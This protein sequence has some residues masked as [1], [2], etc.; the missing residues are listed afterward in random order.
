[1][2]V[3]RRMTRNV[4]TASA[5]DPVARAASLMRENRIHH[6]PVVSGSELEGIVTDTDIRNAALGDPASA[7]GRTVGEIMT[8][9]PVTVGA[10]DTVEDALLLLHRRRFGALPVVEGR[11]LIGIISKAD[12]LSAFIDTL[13]IE[14]VGVR[15]EVLVPGDAASL[16]RLVRAVGETGAE[17]RSLVVS[18]F[19]GQFVAFLRLATIDVVGVRA[20]LKGAG[21]AIPDLSDF[22]D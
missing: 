7:G 8:R 15:L 6:L 16:L 13:D 20:R 19:R 12:I 9:D 5:A 10:W 21:F 4:V 11:K 17:V 2:Y 22:L 3:G 1:M 18:P 14:G